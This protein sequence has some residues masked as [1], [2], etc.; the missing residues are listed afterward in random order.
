MRS[1]ATVLYWQ[2]QDSLAQLAED[3][4][5]HSIPLTIYSLTPGINYPSSDQFDPKI[6]AQVLSAPDAV[7]VWS[8]EPIQEA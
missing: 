4:K 8:F 6:I 3:C 7:P 2:V 5:N 1:I